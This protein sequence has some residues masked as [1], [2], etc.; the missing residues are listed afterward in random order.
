M[1]M[2]RIAGQGSKWLRKT[3]RLALY[4]RA[5]F[6]CVYCPEDAPSLAGADQAE[7]G[8]DHL[9]CSSHGGSNEPANLV[10]IC[11]RHNSQRGTKD[12]EC[13][14]TVAQAVA[15][16]KQIGTPLEPYR[17]M[18]RALIAGTGTWADEEAG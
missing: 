12:W 5:D 7:C 6:R 1:S 15:I 13:L 10:F 8:V 3:T 16:H 17:K 2:A 9:V 4:L 11:R 18:A 14:V